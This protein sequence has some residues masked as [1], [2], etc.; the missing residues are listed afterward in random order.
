MALTKLSLFSST[1]TIPVE[2]FVL[3][4]KPQYGEQILSDSRLDSVPMS[5]ERKSLSAPDAE[6]PCSGM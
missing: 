2:Y 3:I 1:S 5:W 6:K 4:M